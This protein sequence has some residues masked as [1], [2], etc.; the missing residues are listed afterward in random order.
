MSSCWEEKRKII[1][2]A[3]KR[4]IGVLWRLKPDPADLECDVMDDTE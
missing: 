2:R 1:N 3:W 4:L